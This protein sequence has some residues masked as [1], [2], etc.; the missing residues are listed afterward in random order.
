MVGR[1][2]EEP[3]DPLFTGTGEVGAAMARH[4]WSATPVGPPSTWPAELRNVVRILLTSRFSMWMAWGPQLASFYNDAY[5]RDTLQ[6][7][8]P[9]ALGRPA[10][11]MWAEIWPDIGPRIE[12]VLSTGGA[13]WDEDLLL[14]LE[15]HGYP[16]ETYHTFSYSPLGGGGG[17]RADGMLCVVTETTQRVVGERRMATL[18]DLAA[19]VTA[20][21]T[22]SDVLSAVAAQLGRNPRDLPFSLVYLLDEDGARLGAATGIAAGSP[23]APDRIAAGDPDPTWPVDGARAGRPVLVEDLAD[24]GWSL[25]GGAWD[26]PPHQA[27]VVPF[28]AAPAAPGADDD[29]ADDDGAGGPVA[30]FV[31]VGL[32][33]HRRLDDAYTGFLQLVAGQVGAGLVNAGSYEAERRRA[34]ALAE[35]DRAKTDFFSNVSH[36]FRTPLTLITGPLAELRSSPAIAADDAARTELAVIERNAQRLGR[37]VNTLLD[38]S[39]LQAG[40]L[41]ARFEPVDLAAA[42]AELASVFRSAVERAGLRLTVDAPPLPQPVFVDREMWENVVL[43]LLSNA[44]KFTFTGGITVRLQAA[45]DAAVLTVSDTGT[46]IPADEL[47]RLFERFHRVER[48]RSRSGEGSGIGLA[49][50]RELL[51]LHGGTIA[52]DSRAGRGTTFTVRVPLGSAHLPAE[53][54]ADGDDGAAPPAGISAAAE[55]FVSE[56][57]RWLPADDAAGS[58][59]DGRTPDGAPPARTDP[60]GRAPGR[61]LVADDNA[62]MRDYVQRLLAQ[63]Y[64]VEVVADGQAALEAVRADPPDLVVSDVMMPRLD[65]MQLLAAL[66]ADSR[67]ER[68]PVL[69]LSARAGQE[70]AVEGLAAGAD[71]YLVKPFAARE[72]LARV[73]A[74][75]ELGRVRREAEERFTAMADLAPAL[76]WVADADG[77]RVLL[78]A[79]WREFT[80]SG[81]DEDR[82][83]RWQD[84]LHPDDRDRYL[85]V[86]AAASAERR[87]WEVEY[88]LRRADGAYHW[89]LERAVPLDGGQ[90]GHVGACTDIN[91]RY[92]ESQRQALLAEVGAALDRAEG[93]TGQLAALARLLVDSR[94]ADVCDVRRVGDDGRLRREAA[95]ALDPVTEAVLTS[96]DEDTYAARQAVATGRAVLQVQVPDVERTGPAYTDPAL[97]TRRR[98][99]AVTS[100]MSVPL[101]VRGRVLA[102]LGLGRRFDAPGLTDDDVTLAGE[103]AARAALALDNG[104]LLTEERASAARL[105][106]LQRATA[107]LSAATTPDQVAAAAARHVRDLLGPSCRVSVFELDEDRRTLVSLG[108]SG[109]DPGTAEWSR[110]PLSAPGALT[111]AVA[112]RQPVW[113]DGT[114]GSGRPT[115]GEVE[116]LAELG[117]QGAADLPLHAGG[118]VT[119]VL[120]V[121]LPTP[122]PLGPTERATLL[123]LAEQ[124]A[125][126]LDRA[127][128]FRAQRRIAETLQRSLLPQQLPQLDRL[129]LAARYVPGAEGS[130][131]GG[132]WYDVVELDSSRVAV[133]VGDVVGQGPAA[134]AVMGQLRSVLSTALLSGCGPAEALE[135]LDRFAARVPGAL[136]STAACLVLDWSA[137][138][139]RWARAGH[140]PPLLVT[141]DGARL[142]EGAGG[143]TV[144]GVPGR[145]PYTEGH[146]PVGP[147]STLLLYTDGLVERRRETLD[148]GLDRLTGSAARHAG[149]APEALA[150]ALLAELLADT[151][152]PDDVALIAVRLMP[153]AL[154]AR[155]PADARE[156]SRARRAVQAWAEAAALPPDLAE[157]LQLA[158]GEALANAVEHAYRGQRAGEVAYTVSRTAAGDVDVCITDSG[159]WRPVPADRGFRGRGLEMIAVLTTDL[160][161]RPGPAGGTAVHFRLPAAPVPSATPPASGPGAGDATDDGADLRVDGARLVLTGTLDLGSVDALRPRLLAALPGDGQLVTLDLRGVGYLASAGVG[162]L[163]ETTA[164]VRAGGGGV[165]VLVTP[166]SLPARVLD[167]TALS[168]VLGVAPE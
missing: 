152:Q 23:A 18:R 128:L 144:L 168:D 74:H 26:R 3:S 115:P 38:F 106:L 14:F 4:D 27:V 125:L 145:R 44:L 32:N 37:L 10:S 21:R 57:L 142:L 50:V 101:V 13:T 161:L 90:G 54:V 45:D 30:G 31:V 85:A 40:R 117:L 15:R 130:Q 92:R 112:T 8:H 1:R 66:R 140:L 110:V 33:P 146:A 53:Q 129:A 7:K 97:A 153:P 95:A 82:A 121:G 127:R 28:A 163:L 94:L 41:T 124:C 60:L 70:A 143:G 71:D 25:P 103:I 5:W 75:V 107:A 156:L 141:A 138:E 96:L 68:V 133:A 111:E 39:R 34:E 155:V 119:G 35:L 20:A 81:P 159:V 139:V 49:M 165:R 120:G 78:N 73:G 65:G 2:P 104:L 91:A 48:A 12:T 109:H 64:T 166:G 147:G 87:P 16:E 17:E 151:D 100:A 9:W 72:L 148:A 83:G 6:S 102:V 154:D 162:L 29:G 160:D 36:E 88:R 164:Q 69:L 58:T 137:G 122:A 47:P 80:G 46:G 99:L 59:S 61:V 131:A 67:T 89:L 22:E 11:E 98:E 51:A 114:P 79:G 118:R 108:R 56:A 158:F 150:S 93:V 126:A 19:A 76:I 132:D 136:A 116:Q 134:A 63:R 105:A 24:R 62:D 52:A 135:L 157:D 43:N 123:A 149:D 55:P 113:V 42:T 84:G 77:R 86:V 167:V